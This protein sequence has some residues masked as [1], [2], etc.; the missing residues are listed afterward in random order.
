MLHVRRQRSSTARRSGLPPPR[1]ICRPRPNQGQY[2]PK[3]AKP[4]LY[5]QQ[6]AHSFA[7]TGLATYIFSITSALF[8]AREKYNPCVS[9]SFRTIPAVLRTREKTNSLVFM[10]PRTIL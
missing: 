6:F 9:I 1:H 5:F 4:P 2:S 3:L 7:G 10:H 8:A